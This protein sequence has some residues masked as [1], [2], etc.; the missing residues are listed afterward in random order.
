MHPSYV[1]NFE[2]KKLALEEGQKRI[3]ECQKIIGPY[4]QISLIGGSQLK[5]VSMIAIN[6]I[7]DVDKLHELDKILN[8]R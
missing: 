2:E 4:A 6:G 1:E 5:P 8:E 3:D 7:I